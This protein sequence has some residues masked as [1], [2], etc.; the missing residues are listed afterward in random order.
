VD[1]IKLFVNDP[2]VAPLYALLVVS[3]IDFL[4][5]IYRSIQQKVFDPKKLPQLLDSMV[6]KEIIPLAALGA[7]SFFVTDSTAQ[8][9]LQAAYVAGCAAA[10]AGA[11]AAFI[12]KITGVYTPTTIEQDKGR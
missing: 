8:T 3:A 9:G 11:L 12:S 7:A 2:L 10:L 1:Q 4:L 6:L 5:A